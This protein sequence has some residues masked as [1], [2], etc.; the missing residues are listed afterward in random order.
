MTPEEAFAAFAFAAA[1]AAG[2]GSAGAAFGDMAETLFW[3]QQLGQMNGCGQG[4]S[5]PL[6]GFGFPGSPYVAAAAP[7]AGSVAASFG[8][9]ALSVGLWSAGLAISIVGLPRIGGFARHVG[10][11]NDRDRSETNKRDSPNPVRRRLAVLQGISQVVIASQARSPH[12]H[13]PAA[14]LVSWQQVPAVRS[15]ACTAASLGA[16]RVQQAAGRS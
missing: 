4:L 6:P 8:G 2:G 1:C 10:D 14:L 7:A 13:L 5:M 16:A 11:Q 15:A 3:A 9:V 12:A